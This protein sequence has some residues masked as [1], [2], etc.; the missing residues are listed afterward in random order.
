MGRRRLL[1]ISLRHQ[2]MG[3]GKQQANYE[4]DHSAARV[5]SFPNSLHFCS[6][7]ALGSEPSEGQC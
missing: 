1:A 6:Y 3:T 2:D 5:L 7:L 4:Q